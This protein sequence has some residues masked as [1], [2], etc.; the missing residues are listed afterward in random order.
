MTTNRIASVI[1]CEHVEGSYHKVTIK[2]AVGA[3]GLPGL[4]LIVKPKITLHH[5]LFL[6]GAR[7]TREP[8]YVEDV[9]RHGRPRVFAV[10]PRGRMVHRCC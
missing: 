7:G 8:R 5:F 9:P 4:N 10:G 2:D 3:I 1:S 6:L